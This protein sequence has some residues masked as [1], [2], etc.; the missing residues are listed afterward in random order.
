VPLITRQFGGDV[1]KFI[2]DGIMATFNSRG[3][4]PDRAKR[5]SCAALALQRRVTRLSERHPDWPPLRVG[6]NSGSVVVREIGS[7][8]HVVYPSVGDAVNTGARLESLAPA[9]GV[10]IGPETYEQL[11]DGA[12]VEER[13]GLRVNGKERVVDAYVL[14]A[15][16]C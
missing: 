6:V 14:H 3:D 5:A 11:P 15:L 7:H 8:G 4:Q 13:A 16:P 1:E 10:L 9:G 2:G 12:I